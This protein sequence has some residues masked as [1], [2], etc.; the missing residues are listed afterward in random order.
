MANKSLYTRELGLAVAGKARPV[1]TG[2]YH[3]ISA[4]A[5]KWSVV[6]EGSVH[7][8]KAFSTQKEAITYAKQTASKKTGEV[9]VHSKA[10]QVRNKISFAK[11]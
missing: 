6:P 4:I 5:E 2:R 10:G 1:K 8:V 11:K 9:I 3:V 7:A